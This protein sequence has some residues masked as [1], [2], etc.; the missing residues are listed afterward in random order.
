[1]RRDLNKIVNNDLKDKKKEVI[2]VFA[3]EFLGEVVDK[4]VNE[5]FTTKMGITSSGLYFE[6]YPPQ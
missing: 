1:L 5:I 2:L 3:L 6:K 4:T